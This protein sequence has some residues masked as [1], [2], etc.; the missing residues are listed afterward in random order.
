M[1][2]SR[3]YNNIA[4]IQL[5]KGSLVEAEQSARQATTNLKLNANGQF[6]VALA[7]G[8]LATA[9]RTMEILKKFNVP[10]R[11]SRFTLRRLIYYQ[12]RLDLLAGARQRPLQ[13]LRKR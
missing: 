11:G 9:A 6:L 13:T 4:R 3:G 10:Q 12:G 7:K 5:Q 8:D 1:E 2:R